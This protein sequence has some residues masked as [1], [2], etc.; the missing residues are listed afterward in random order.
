MFK[1]LPTLAAYSLGIFLGLSIYYKIENK[2]LFMDEEFEPYYESFLQEAESYEVPVDFSFSSTS[3]VDKLETGTAGICIS[4]KNVIVSR[5]LWGVLSPVERQVLLYHEWGHC[6]LNRSHNEKTLVG[7]NCP[8]SMMYP[9]IDKTA[10][11]LYKHR[12]WY[13]QELL[14]NPTNNPPLR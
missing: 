12:N 1:Y 8:A 4:T 5:Q 2:P 13:M 9:T 10:H 14:F 11:C 3:F 6:I 7:E